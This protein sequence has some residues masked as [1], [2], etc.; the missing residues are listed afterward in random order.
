MAADKKKKKR[1]A[2]LVTYNGV[3]MRRD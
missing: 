3:E 1:K 2:D